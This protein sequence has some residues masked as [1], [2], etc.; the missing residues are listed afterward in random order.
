[1]GSGMM[2]DGRCYEARTGYRRR[3]TVSGLSE[4]L[5]AEVDERYYLSPER[6]RKILEAD[7]QKRRESAGEASPTRTSAS[8]GTP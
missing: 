4:C 5:E 7:A 3:G 1:M 2:R 6:V 8:G